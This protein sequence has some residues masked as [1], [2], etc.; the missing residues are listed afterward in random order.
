MEGGCGNKG[1]KLNT[2][3]KRLDGA[4]DREGKQ[5]ENNGVNEPST[6][7]QVKW[8]NLVF[9]TKFPCIHHEA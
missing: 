4:R 5:K 1:T 8:N 2:A 9:S 6:F 7:P 3:K